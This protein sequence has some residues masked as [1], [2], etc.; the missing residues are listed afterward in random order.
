MTSKSAP[1]CV[2]CRPGAKSPT[3]SHGICKA[4]ADA[5][6][7]QAAFENARCALRRRVVAEMRWGAEAAKQA[8]KERA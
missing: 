3:G 5:S 2:W 4:C 8:V 7:E 1:V 6:L